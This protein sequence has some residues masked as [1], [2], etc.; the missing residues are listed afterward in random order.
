MATAAT[1][2]TEMFMFTFLQQK[3]H[4]LGLFTLLFTFMR[5]SNAKSLSLSNSLNWLYK[6]WH[7]DF[8]KIAR[9][10]NTSQRTNTNQKKT[11]KGDI[12]Q[13]IFQTTQ[14]IWCAGIYCEK[15]ENK[16][17]LCRFIHSIQRI[18]VVIYFIQS[19]HYRNSIMN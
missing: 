19:F 3:H 17:S 1:A 9:R 2:A 8:L 4:P 11:W 16:S 18:Y 5:S 10:R 12:V 13:W 15:G 14:F 7:T 6:P